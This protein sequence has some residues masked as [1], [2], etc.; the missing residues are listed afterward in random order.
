MSGPRAETGIADR[1]RFPVLLFAEDG[2]LSGFDTVEGAEGAVEAPD[3]GHAEVFD[4]A[5]RRLRLISLAE[6][7]REVGPRR[8]GTTSVDIGP[9]RLAEAEQRPGDGPEHVRRR[10]VEVFVLH[11]LVDAEA[12]ELLTL[13]DALAIVRAGYMRSGR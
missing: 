11:G 4:A 7:P 13:D 9:V 10:I 2:D 5:G 8:L 6:P 3:V 1:I 12:G